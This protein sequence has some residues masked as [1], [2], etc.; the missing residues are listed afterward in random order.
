MSESQV[1]IKSGKFVDNKELSYIVEDNGYSIYL[2]ETLWI[3]QYE[4]Y[5]P[6]PELGYEGSCIKQIEEL[7]APPEP[8]VEDTKVADLEAKVTS[9]EEELT[10]TQ[11]AL[12]E[13]Y[14]ENITLQEEI[15]NT[16]LALTEIYESML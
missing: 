2:G 6:F 4:P 13:Q 10:T 5:I 9:L 11:L 1:M 8:S 16:E 14:E 7:T 15:T 3:T 12:T